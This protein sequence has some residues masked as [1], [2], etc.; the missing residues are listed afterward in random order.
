MSW[1]HSLRRKLQEVEDVLT[2]HTCCKL[3]SR[4]VGVLIRIK[5]EGQASPR[6]C[7]YSPN[8]RC[9]CSK[10]SK[11]RNKRRKAVV[12]T[13]YSLFLYFITFIANKLYLHRKVESLATTEIPKCLFFIIAALYNF[14]HPTVSLNFTSFVS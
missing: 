3:F 7:V 4:I 2:L 5:K 14:S 13:L 8:C 6:P 11:C 1:K 9:S 12:I 10:F